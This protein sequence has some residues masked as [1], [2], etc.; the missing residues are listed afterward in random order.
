MPIVFMGGEA[1][2]A[3]RSLRREEMERFGSDL[4]WLR[5]P[6]QIP[7]WAV[8][9]PD[10]EHRGGSRRNWQAPGHFFRR[11]RRKCAHATL[12]LTPHRPI[13]VRTVYIEWLSGLDVLFILRHNL[14][15]VVLKQ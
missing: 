14:P 2:K 9:A 1:A 3:R 12:V 4:E 7:E 10:I 13:Q 6:S 5:D 8:R 11:D 15:F